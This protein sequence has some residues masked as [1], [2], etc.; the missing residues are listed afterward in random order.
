MVKFELELPL[1]SCGGLDHENV[2]L[3]GTAEEVG[4]QLTDLLLS[5]PE[6]K[7][8]KAVSNDNLGVGEPQSEECVT[9]WW[10]PSNSEWSMG[11]FDEN[12]NEV[13]CD[14]N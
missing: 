13:D 6:D 5:I 1:G 12:S 7:Y 9:L 14:D 4:K 3:S 2:K 8:R 10:K 11:H